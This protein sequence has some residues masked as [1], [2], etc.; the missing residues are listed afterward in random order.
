MLPAE[1]CNVLGASP[2]H[3]AHFAVPTCHC[4]PCSAWSWMEGR[5]KLG[6]NTLIVKLAAEEKPWC[7][8]GGYWLILKYARGNLFVQ[9]N[10]FAMYVLKAGLTCVSKWTGKGW[11]LPL[12]RERCCPLPHICTE[13]SLKRSSAD[14]IYWVCGQRDWNPPPVH[15]QG[16]PELIQINRNVSSSDPN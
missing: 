14:E 13:T 11:A 10:I 1:V 7:K 15:G 2:L 3:G 4:S 8:I 9:V 16:S 5:E 12:V 6:L